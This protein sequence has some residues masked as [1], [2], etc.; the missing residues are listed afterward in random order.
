MNSHTTFDVPTATPVRRVTG[1]YLAKNRLTARARAQLAA[2]IVSGKVVIDASTLTVGQIIRLC[3]SNL[4]YV[5]QVRFP[6]RARRHQQ[7]R[8]QSTFDAIGP[9]A[10]AEVCRTIGV[11]RWWGVLAQALG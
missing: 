2:D 7:E 5:D 11:E 9:D 4:V 6:E 8:I 1:Q 10:R 3:R